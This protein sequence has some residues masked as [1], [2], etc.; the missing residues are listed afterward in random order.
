MGNRDCVIFAAGEYYNNIPTVSS[1]AFIVAA[2]AGL[3]ACRVFG[4]RPDVILGDFDSLGTIPTDN[5]VITL[6]VEKDVTDTFAAVEE[7]KKHGCT[8][9][10][11]YGAMGGRPDHTYAN[12]ALAADLSR[13]NCSCTLFGD[14]YTVTAI[15]DTS[16]EITGEIGSTVSLFS[17]SE[18]SEGVTLEGLKYSLNNAA[19]D[20]Y[21][22]LGVSNEFKENKAKITVK[23]GT[24]IIM[25]QKS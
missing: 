17:F 20:C 7:G 18:K 15:T 4:I 23:N 25:Q 9:F 16:L 12:I 22:P 8:N 14:R 2:D 11:V 24:L 3:K 6:P 21:F 13:Q 1:G 10:S 5:N 19:L